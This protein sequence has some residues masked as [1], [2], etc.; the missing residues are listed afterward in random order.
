MPDHRWSDEVEAQ[1]ICLPLLHIVTSSAAMHTIVWEMY[2][3]V[4]Q[5][6]FE[7]YN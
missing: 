7:K 4:M 3:Q 5:L 6:V 2:L 1:F